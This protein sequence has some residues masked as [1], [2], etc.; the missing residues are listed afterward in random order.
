MCNETCKILDLK[1]IQ[2]DIHGSLSREPD[3]H[4]FSFVLNELKAHSRSFSSLYCF[5]RR[6][7][8]IFTDVV[9]TDVVDFKP[10]AIKQNMFLE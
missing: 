9:G 7:P 2:S 10:H 8:R 5:A 1:I 4:F 3:S 6:H